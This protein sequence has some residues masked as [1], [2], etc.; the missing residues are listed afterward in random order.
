MKNQNLMILPNNEVITNLDELLKETKELYEQQISYGTKRAY[1]FDWKVFVNWCSENNL[2]AEQ[3]TPYIVS[4]FLTFEFKKKHRHPST[5]NR[6]LAAIKFWFKTR[7]L[8]SPTDDE[9]VHSVLKGIRR[10]KNVKPSKSKKAIT[11]EVI[12]QMIDL[13]STD[14]I[15]DIRDRAILLLGYCG[16]Y[17]ENELVSINIDDITFIDGKGMDIFHRYTKTDQEG[18]GKIKPIIKAQ[19]LF[20]YCPIRAVKKWI[21]AAKITTGALFRG[22]NKHGKIENT[23][24][25]HD[26]VYEVIK[27]CILK[28]GY[29]YNEYSSHCLRVGFVTQALR[30]G[31][32]IDKIPSVTDHKSIRSLEFYIQH[33]DRY[34]DHPGRNIF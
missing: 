28:L 1:E 16:A 3:A 29:E 10:D 2:I 15:R 18:K 17:R 34:E 27:R 5:I 4:L 6:R 19:V 21:E 24:M 13:C 30:S 23:R 26:V 25:S 20:Q 11:K 33:E 31:A 8:K 12:M 7:N 9:L 22:I 14:D 32:R